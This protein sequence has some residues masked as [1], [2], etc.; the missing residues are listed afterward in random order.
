MSVH[1]VLEIIAARLDNKAIEVHRAGQWCNWFGSPREL[2]KMLDAG[3]VFR[4]KRVPRTIYAATKHGV[5]SEQFWTDK[6]DALN[7]CLDGNL[8]V[9]FVEVLK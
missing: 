6:D 3:E 8:L 9:E 1:S 7:N 2:V 5:L 4:V